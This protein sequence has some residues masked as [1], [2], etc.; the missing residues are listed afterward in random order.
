MS[1]TKTSRKDKSRGQT[2][3]MIYVNSYFFQKKKVHN[4]IKLFCHCVK[5]MLACVNV[6]V[7]AHI[8]AQASF[9]N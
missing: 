7:H 5:N 3:T 9:C 1:N 4:K 6:T 2:I 8:E